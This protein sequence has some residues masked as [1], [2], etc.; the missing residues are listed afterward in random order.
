MNTNIVTY[1]NDFDLH[2]VVTEPK[3]EGTEVIYVPFDL[4]TCTNVAVSLLCEKHNIDIPLN[5]EMVE[6][7]INEIIARVLGVSL[8]SGSSYGCTITGTKEDGSH[9]R[10]KAKGKEMF[11]VIDGTNGAKLDSDLVEDY[12]DVN[13][14]IGMVG[15][16]GPQGEVGPQGEKGDQGEQGPQGPAGEDHYAELVQMINSEAQTRST[17][18]LAIQQAVESIG[19]SLT[20]KADKST[21]YT[22]TEV[23]DIIDNIELTPGPQGEQG[24]QGEVGPQGPEG[25]GSNINDYVIDYSKRYF[26]VEPLAD[27]NIKFNN[28]GLSYSRDNGVT[29]NTLEANINISMTT[30]N[31][32]I[33]KGTTM[34]TGN[35]ALGSF[36]GTANYKVSGNIESLVHGDNFIGKTDCFCIANFFIDDTYIIGAENLIIPATELTVSN[37]Y[38]GAFAR[39]TNFKYAPKLPATTLSI[40]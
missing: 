27:G 16:K 22:K 21:T 34:P 18:D 31:D 28:S 7:T 12:L 40:H 25:G 24:P 1:G 32:I 8:H 26:T 39:C 17:A 14:R 29:W 11:T 6:G 19:S 4:T 30:G 3:V 5:W 33:F 10:W 36:R 37:C 13:V 23:D 35:D 9:F 38:Q 2:I 15:G 20:N